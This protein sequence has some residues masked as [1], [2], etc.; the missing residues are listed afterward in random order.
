M[1]LA[2]AKLKLVKIINTILSH[3]SLESESPENGLEE[4]FVIV[5]GFY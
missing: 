3:Q 1:A 2:C 4:D 5:M